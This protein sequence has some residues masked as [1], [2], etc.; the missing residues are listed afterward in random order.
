MVVQRIN[1]FS[2]KFTINELVM[3]YALP[4]LLII[5]IGLLVFKFVGDKKDVELPVMEMPT[6]I[7]TVKVKEVIQ[8][9]NYTYLYVK[10]NGKVYWMAVNKMVAAEGDNY[11]Y[12]TTSAN[13]MQDFHSKEL[14]R[15][16]ESILFVQDL[17]G[18]DSGTGRPIPT[19]HNT[20]KPRTEQDASIAVDK[21]P[22]GITVA[23][24]MKDKKKL[25][26]KK[27]TIRGK[28]VK[29]NNMIMN[30]NWIHIQD[31][32][33]LD[34]KYDLTITS[35]EEVEEGAVVTFVGTVGV[36][37]DFG[38]GYFYDLIIEDAVVDKN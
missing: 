36:D 9:S 31:G 29:V 5:A 38:A 26:G 13:E 22:N 3:K 17:F 15:T 4:A 32:T 23:D 28:V 10:E 1:Y 19:E 18:T 27:V 35:N 30:R 14:D 37:K 24:L 34:G 33:S 21:A 12:Q 25:S 7:H 16:F 11:S 20:S 6:G 8:T 2:R